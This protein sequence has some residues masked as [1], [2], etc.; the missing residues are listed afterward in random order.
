[1]SWI[2]IL[3]YIVMCVVDLF[4]TFRFSLDKDDPDYRVDRDTLVSLCVCWPLMLPFKL[5]VLSAPFWEKVF[6]R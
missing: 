3:G 6:S 1:M 2:I 4:V 5:I